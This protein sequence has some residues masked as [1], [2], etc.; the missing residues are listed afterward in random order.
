MTSPRVSAIVVNHRSVAEADGCVR[1]LRDAFARERVEGE[2]VLVDSDSGPEER[3]ILETLPADTH[4]FLE[5]NRGYSGGVN[6]GITRARAPRAF[7]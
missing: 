4:V 1:S 5:E 7:I 3:K 2:I 6:A